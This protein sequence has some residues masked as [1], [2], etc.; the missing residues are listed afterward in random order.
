LATAQVMIDDGADLKGA[1]EIDRSPT[2]EADKKVLSR[3][4]S[5]GAMR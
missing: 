5:D 3:A 1:I 4:A 2:K